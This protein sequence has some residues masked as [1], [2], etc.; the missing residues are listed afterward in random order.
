MERQKINFLK[1]ANSN[2]HSN[3]QNNTYFN[4]VQKIQPQFGETHIHRKIEANYDFGQIQTITKAQQ[5]D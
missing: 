2:N 4:Q 1:F 3:R 5:F